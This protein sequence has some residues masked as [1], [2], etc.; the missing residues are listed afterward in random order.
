M[1]GKLGWACWSRLGW[2]A[3]LWSIKPTKC[4]NNFPLCMRW[5]GARESFHFMVLSKDAHFLD[6]DFSS[7]PKQHMCV[8]HVGLVAA[9][10][11]ER[12]SHFWLQEGLAALALPWK[13]S[14]PLWCLRASLGHLANWE[15]RYSGG[16]QGSC[17]GSHRAI[18][19]R[20]VR[21]DRRFFVWCLRFWG[22]SSYGFMLRSGICVQ[23]GPEG[24]A[25]F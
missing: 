22:K 16:V 20:C 19:T 7:F 6:E 10:A 13:L 8:R 4:Q 21:R 15:R 18:R 2:G 11:L 25:L 12:D 1:A 14:E 3:S 23:A 24:K 9:S 5:L 17:A